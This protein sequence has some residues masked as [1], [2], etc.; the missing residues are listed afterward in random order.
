MKLATTLLLS[1]LSVAQAATIVNFGQTG[2]DTLSSGN[3]NATLNH[4]YD[5]LTNGYQNPANGTNGYSTEV[6]GQTR[7]FYGAISTPANIYGINGDHIQMVYN[8]GGSGGNVT[9]MIAWQQEDFL[10]HNTGG[11]SVTSFDMEFQTRGGDT[12]A[13]YLIETADGW[14]Q[15]QVFTNDDYTSTAKNIGDLTW[16]GFDNFGVTNGADNEAIADT[17]SILSVGA[18]FDSTLASGTNWT[19]AKLRYF[20][21]AGTAAVPEPSSTALLGLGGLSFILRRRR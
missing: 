10:T 4:T 18:Y 2:G 16:S 19:G 15:S 7:K 20:N 1:A 3:A 9:S 21:V 17:D 12:T 5:P 8:T 6:A 13:Y 11:V 14:Y